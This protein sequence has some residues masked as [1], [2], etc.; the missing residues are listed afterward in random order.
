MVL[1]NFWSVFED[2]GLFRAAPSIAWNTLR[3]LRNLYSFMVS[4]R[5]Q[6]LSFIGFSLV[7]FASALLPL[8]HRLARALSISVHLRRGI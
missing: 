8:E 4:T 5:H 2:D 3:L 7:M 1:N 6:R